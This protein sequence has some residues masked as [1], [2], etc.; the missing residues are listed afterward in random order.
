VLWVFLFN[1]TLGILPYWL[2]RV[3][4][5]WNHVLDDDHAIALVVMASVWKQISYN[6]L[7]FLAG[8]QSIP[9]SLVEAAAIDGAGWWQKFWHVTLPLLR[10]ML[11]FVVIMSV[12]TSFQVF[13][14][15]YIMTS[16]AGEGSIGG[17]LDSGLTIVAYLYDM[18]FQK[19][20]MGYASALAFLLFI[21]LFGLTMVNLRQLRSRVEY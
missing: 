6:F 17:I 5:T 7:F 1:P 3:G 14:Q 21:S 2:A 11:T 16:G 19:F 12:I 18:G 8:L 10:P 13:D 4:F 9:K 15:V 20:Q